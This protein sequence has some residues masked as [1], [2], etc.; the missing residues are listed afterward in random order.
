LCEGGDGGI[1]KSATGYPD[2][3]TAY[4]EKL[5][6][7]AGATFSLGL[8]RIAEEEH[9]RWQDERHK[10]QEEREQLSR[11]IKAFEN[12]R[13]RGDLGFE[14]N[15]IRQAPLPPPPK[16]TMPILEGSQSESPKYHIPRS[17]YSPP[18]SPQALPPIENQRI[19]MNSDELRLNVRGRSIPIN[20]SVLIQCKESKLAE[21]FARLESLRKDAFGEIPIEFPPD[22]FEPLVDHLKKR[23]TDSETSPPPPL[24][25][26]T[27]DDDFIDMLRYY[28]MLEW[29]YRQSPVKFQ[30][31]IGQYDYAV[32]PPQPPD[33][34]Q[35]L[36]EMREQ[37]ITVPR[38]WKILDTSDDGFEKAIS[39]MTSKSWGTTSLLASDEDY[40]FAGYRTPLSRTGMA[41]SRV[42]P[43]EV[44]TAWFDTISRDRR[45][46]RFASGS[47][48][49]VIRS[50]ASPKAASGRVAAQK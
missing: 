49:L 1:P 40:G 4:L 22:I 28:G 13:L 34:G 32:L 27:L 19:D 43:D 39:K 41:G 9:R 21:D 17:A 48:R 3:P 18:A 25:N 14:A 7:E 29:V 38:G 30:L 15:V 45:Q 44:T 16:A 6:Q 12:A 33:M 26:P 37:T 10:I 20:R 36:Y 2:F 5:A 42:N 31:R 24:S 47:Y 46:L 23:F 11:Q 50:R 8:K 35:D